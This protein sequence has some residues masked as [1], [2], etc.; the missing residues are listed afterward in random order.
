MTDLTGSTRPLR[1]PLYDSEVIEQDFADSSEVLFDLTDMFP[2]DPNESTLITLNISLNE[3]VALASAIDVGRDIA[4]GDNALYIWWI[5]LKVVQMDICDLVADCIL[6]S[7]NVQNALNSVINVNS[8]TDTYNYAQ[9]QSGVILGDGN[10]PTCDLDT[11]WGG[12]S[13]LIEQTNQQNIDLL[14]QFEVATN[15]QDFMSQVVGNVT[16]IDETSIDAIFGWIE[17]IQDN[18]AENYAAQVTQGYLDEISCGLFCLAKDTCEL[19]PEMIY[20]YFMGR[21]SGAITFDSIISTALNFIVAGTWAGT[22][23]ADAFFMSNLMMRANFGKFFE[24]VGFNSFDTSMR[25]GFLQPSSAWTLLCEC[26]DSWEHTFDFTA[27]DGGWYATAPADGNVLGTYVASQGWSTTDDLFAQPNYYARAVSI[28]IDFDQTNITELEMTYN[29][30]KGSWSATGTAMSINTRL[31]NVV[32]MSYTESSDV[33]DDGN[34]EN[35]GVVGDVQA[36]NAR[37]LLDASRV[38]SQSYSGSALITS[39]TIRGTGTNPFI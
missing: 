15:L 20:D 6:T 16:G 11:L 24:W 25:L 2:E 36:D 13:F 31:T 38:Q 8:S 19:T 3:Y 9:N 27:N 5:W 29:Y 37:L 23:I 30:Q 1:F 14:E 18:I 7:E 17:F 32:T 22:E 10:N 12:V 28:R 34:G 33:I 21:L 26:D 4:Y 39:C 35:N